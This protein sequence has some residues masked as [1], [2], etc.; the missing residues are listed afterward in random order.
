MALG[1]FPEG[2]SK[3]LSLN[4]LGKQTARSSHPLPSSIPEEA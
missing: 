3:I 2:E 1:G 4:D